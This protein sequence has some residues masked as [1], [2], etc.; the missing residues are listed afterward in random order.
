MEQNKGL[1][2]LIWA[3]FPFFFSF[4]LFGKISITVTPS[5]LSINLKENVL[6]DSQ[7]QILNSGDVDYDV[8]VSFYDMDQLEDGEVEKF[9]PNTTKR[10][11]GGWLSSDVKSF[12]LKS[13]EKYLFKYYIDVP[14]GVD[15]G[16]AGGILFTIKTKKEAQEFGAGIEAGVLSKLYVTISEEKN[17]ILD[18]KDFK[19]KKDEKGNSYY[20]IISLENKTPFFSYFKGIFYLKDEK[21][22]TIYEKKISSERGVFPE[23]SL[24]IRYKIEKIKKGNLIGIL[25]LN[26]NEERPLIKTIYFKVD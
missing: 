26:L 24:E 22:E 1:K 19:I 5:F 17:G 9:E 11:I 6:Y 12:P 10:G 20:F 25:V 2:S 18:I 3:L 7:I 15:G 13:G 14:K 4:N 21:G 8:Y 23:K 16:Y